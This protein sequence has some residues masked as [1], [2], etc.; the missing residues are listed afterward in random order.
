[1]IQIHSSLKQQQQHMQ[2]LQEQ[3]ESPPEPL[4][5]YEAPTNKQDKI[6][7]YETKKHRRRSRSR[8]HSRTRHPLMDKE[9]NCQL[10]PVTRQSRSVSVRKEKNK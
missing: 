1:M 10:K 6:E 9:N 2:Q 5:E 8:S 3:L 7:F 4:V